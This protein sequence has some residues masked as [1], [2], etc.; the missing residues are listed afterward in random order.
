MHWTLFALAGLALSGAHLLR[1]PS[2]SSFLTGFGAF[3]IS[4]LATILLIKLLA[5]AAGIGRATQF[6]GVV[7]QALI[8]AKQTDAPLIVFSGASFSRNAIDDERLTLALNERGY[9]VR[10]LNISLEAASLLERREHLRDFLARTPRKPSIIF[11]EVA[12]I[13]DERPTFI[14][15]NSK[16]SARAIDQFG[17]DE[18]IWAAMGLAGGACNGL[19]DCARESVLLASHS[20]MNMFNVGLIS[21][22]EITANAPPIR[23]FEGVTT[24]REN[25]DAHMRHRQLSEPLEVAPMNAIKWAHDFRILER[26]DYLKAGAGKI[27]YYF[28][29]VISADNRFY[30]AD[31]CAGEL[32]DKVCL[33]PNA[34]DLLHRLDDDVWLDAEHLLDSGAAIY[35][36]WLADQIIASGILGLPASEPMGAPEE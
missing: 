8:L 24:I 12:R 29:P 4:I 1:L 30:M 34:P 25:V 3:S 21:K 23:S 16:F 10:I 28:P 15:S 13:T 31:L 32:A 22:G 27:A 11:L 33:A 9:H 17:V 2:K 26:Q 18:T 20:L 6:D 7:N 14:F 5:G 35:T 36:D 19:S